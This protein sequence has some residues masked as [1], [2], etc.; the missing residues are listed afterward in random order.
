M[1]KKSSTAR[2]RKFHIDKRAAE[3]AATSDE[4]DDRPI[5]TAEAAKWLGVSTQFLEDSAPHRR[6][7][8]IY[9]PRT[10]MHSLHHPLAAG[11]VRGAQSR[12]HEGIHGEMMNQAILAGMLD[13]ELRRAL[14]RLREAG[15]ERYADDI[16]AIERELAWQSHTKR[17]DEIKS[18]REIEREKKRSAR[19][20]KCA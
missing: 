1:S 12:A 5:T 9:A 17:L 8:A 13:H 20:E 7:P 11:V 16:V 18:A 3:L 14:A 15:E 4:D 19:E 2:P 10:A 6:R